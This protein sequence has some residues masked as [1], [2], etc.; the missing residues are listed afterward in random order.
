MDKLKRKLQ[1]SPGHWLQ[2]RQGLASVLLAALIAI[3]LVQMA[4]ACYL[5]DRIL[6]GAALPLRF[7]G[8]Q[9][10]WGVFGPEVPDVNRHVL[11]IVTMQ[12][13]TQAL[14]D[15]P[16]MEKLDLTARAQKE[17]FRKWS[18]DNLMQDY[19]QFLR[20]DAA[21]F[22]ARRF[23]TSGSQPRSVSILTEEQPIR[24][25]EP[26]VTVDMRN[27]KTYCLF[28]YDASREPVE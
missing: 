25:P 2:V 17:Y 7:L 3:S 28:T 11:A 22:A 6:S 9:Q 20:L 19:L 18:H 4:P 14:W 8:L 13:G 16:R 12:D 23:E 1:V 21:R 26:G 27:P 24:R 15:F 10:L 5:R